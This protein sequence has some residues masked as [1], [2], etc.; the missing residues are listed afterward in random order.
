MYRIYIFQYFGCDLPENS[1]RNDG[2]NIFC[3]KKETQ[4]LQIFK[5]SNY[6]SSKL[7]Y[8]IRI[9]SDRKDERPNLKNVIQVWSMPYNFNSFL[10]FRKFLE[11]SGAAEVQ[12]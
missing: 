11:C 2:R 8:K 12:L 9:E 1:A 6:Y 4:I 5:K 7:C 10:I 3:A